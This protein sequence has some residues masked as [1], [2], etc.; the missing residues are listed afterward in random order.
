MRAVVA[1]VV[2]AVVTAPARADDR[3]SAAPLA[4]LD[5]RAA[6]G[7]FDAAAVGTDVFNKGNP[8]GCYWLYRGALVGL[9]PLL[10]HR[11]E[12]VESIRKRLKES[13]DQKTAGDAAHVLRS[14]LDDIQ[15]LIRKPATAPPPA[16]K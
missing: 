5:R 10:D 6:R 3:P 1:A 7:A 13:E 16:S 2:V 12:L 9:L 8:E 4:E 14:A 11:P 15:A